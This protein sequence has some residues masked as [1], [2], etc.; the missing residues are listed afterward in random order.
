MAEA[1][2][3]EHD[4]IVSALRERDPER[5]RRAMVEHIRGLKARALG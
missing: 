2:N 1:S 3:R 4:A 5:A